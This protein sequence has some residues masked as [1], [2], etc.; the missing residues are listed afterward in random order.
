L[1]QLEAEGLQSD[2]RFC[3]S[4]VRQRSG[5]GYGSER[6]RM[7]LHQKGAAADLAALALESCEVDWVALAR[8]TRRKKFGEEIPADFKEKSR[9]LRFL[10]Y[11]GFA[12]ETLALALQLSE[13]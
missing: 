3:E 10:Q 2:E 5:R 1:Q 11:R 9:Q 12:G 8:S 13:D 4:Y 7:E 6:I